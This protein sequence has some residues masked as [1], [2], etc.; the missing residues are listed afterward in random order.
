MKNLTP[1]SMRCAIG[2]SCSSI[3]QL[4]D[5]RLLIVGLDPNKVNREE[6]PDLIQQKLAWWDA[7]NRIAW[8]EAAIVID[9]T[10]LADAVKA[11][12][13]TAVQAER[14]RISKII[15]DAFNF[16]KASV[17]EAFSK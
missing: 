15:I 12:V 4:K 9:R 10:L 8:N 6:D 1:E 7:G 5:G 3:H 17:D 16:S 11:E 2:A 14:D 13:E